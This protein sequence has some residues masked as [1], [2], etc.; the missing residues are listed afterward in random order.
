MADPTIQTFC[1]HRPNRSDYPVHVLMA[2]HSD[3]YNSVC[4]FSSLL[5]IFGAVYQVFMFFTRL[6]FAGGGT[7]TQLM[8][9]FGILFV[10]K[11]SAT[12]NVMLIHAKAA[13]VHDQHCK[14]VSYCILFKYRC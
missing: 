8:D 13:K 9:I 12:F 6:F 14:N 10:L 3:L 11:V 1:C 5:G 7:I 4:V 2:F